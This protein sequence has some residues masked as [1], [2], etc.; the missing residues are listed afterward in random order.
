ML[1]SSSKMYGHIFFNYVSGSAG[2][3]FYCFM[4]EHFSLGGAI[5]DRPT[6]Q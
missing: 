5:L 2:S 3:K 6:V 1:W 4:I